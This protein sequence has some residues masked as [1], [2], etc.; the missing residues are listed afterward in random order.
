MIHRL[1]MSMRA[2]LRVKKEGGRK[3]L[4]KVIKVYLTLITKNRIKPAKLRALPL[5]RYE[6]GEYNAL[7][8]PYKR[9]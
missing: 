2:E 6:E 1:R 8:G 5:S 3:K 7:V 9:I 4:R